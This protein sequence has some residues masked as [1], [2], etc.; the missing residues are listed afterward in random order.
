MTYSQALKS[1]FGTCAH[2]IQVIGYSKLFRLSFDFTDGLL[3]VPPGFERGLILRVSLIIDL[4][5]YLEID[6][7]YTVWLI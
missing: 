7:I 1:S 4:R 3:T 5:V 6:L 2:V